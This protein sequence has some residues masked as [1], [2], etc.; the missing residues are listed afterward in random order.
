LKTG[1]AEFLFFK[2]R[3][4]FT[5]LGQKLGRPVPAGSAT[6][7]QNIK[8]FHEIPLERLNEKKPIITI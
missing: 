4:G 8:F 1:T 7:D 2:Q 3:D 6:N 5:A